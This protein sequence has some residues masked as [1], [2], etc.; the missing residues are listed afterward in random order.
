[1]SPE[2]HPLVVVVLTPKEEAC[3][4]AGALVA[5]VP[6]SILQNHE[7]LGNVIPARDR[8]LGGGLCGTRRAL[9]PEGVEGPDDVVRI[10]FLVPTLEGEGSVR[11]RYGRS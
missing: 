5:R 3:V 2:P 9:I 11:R 10:L 7:R 1:M 4:V 6:E 8:A